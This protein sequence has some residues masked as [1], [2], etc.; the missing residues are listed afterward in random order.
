MPNTYWENNYDPFKDPLFLASFMLL[1][2][3]FGLVLI[4]VL[5]FIRFSYTDYQIQLMPSHIRFKRFKSACSPWRYRRFIAR[6]SD[7]RGDQFIF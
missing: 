6:L 7:K 1:L 5:V 3:L 2:F 4:V